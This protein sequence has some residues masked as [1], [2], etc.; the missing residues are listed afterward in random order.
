M[1]G[2]PSEGIL[3]TT[4][5]SSTYAEARQKFLALASKRGAK[6]VSVVHPTARGAQD[7][8]L[9]I[10]VATFGDPD[11]DK[12]LFLVSGTHGQ[13]G[14]LGSALQIEFLRDLEIPKGVNVV[15]LH[16]LNPWGFSHLSRTDDTNIDVNRNFTDYGVP[17]PQD[18]LYPILFRALCPD[19][20]TEET[21]EWSGVRD[22]LARDYGVKRMV[23][24]IGGGQIIEPSAMNYVGKGPSWS[25]TVV[26][27]LLPNVLGKA[28]KVA[29]I[30]W[31]TGLGKYGGLSHICMMKP[32]SP[33]YERV[34]E[35]LGEEARSSWSKSMDFTDGVTPDYRG[36]FSAWLPS[37]APQTEWAGLVVEVGTY[38]VISVV[39]ALRMDR[40]LKFGRGRSSTPREEIRKTMME[41]LYPQAP[42][43]RAAALE[44]GLDAQRRAFQGLQQW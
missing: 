29:F 4:S 11:A 26:E 35:W 3:M 25:R 30:E 7:E 38:D 19:D 22:Q 42:E 43:W 39:D 18:E 23:T 17:F 28:K 16:G 15:A 37:T 27:K 14:F 1:L 6:V 24:A 9:A 5:F 34:F 2:K 8:D 31:H 41:R 20:W 10:D 32:G 13:E 36:W 12:T 21:I 44:N 40:W 33:G